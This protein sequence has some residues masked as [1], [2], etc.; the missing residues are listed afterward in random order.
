MLDR[1][2][3]TAL[4]KRLLRS[5]ERLLQHHDDEVLDDVGLRPRRA[6]AVVL[7]L[8]THDVLGDLRSR[9]TQRT[10]IA[11]SHRSAALSAP[12]RQVPVRAIAGIS[13]AVR[14]APRLPRLRRLLESRRRQSLP[15]RARGTLP[16]GAVQSRSW[17]GPGRLEPKTR[18]GGAA[19]TRFDDRDTTPSRRPHP[20]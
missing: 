14:A 6:L 7:G 4:G 15:G 18:A 3:L 2:L 12:R 1:I 17:M 5:R 13:R 19:P 11:F 20:R 10:P 8:E 16:N 9:L